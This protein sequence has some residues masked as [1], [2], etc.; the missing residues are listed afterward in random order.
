MFRLSQFIP[1][2]LLFFITNNDRICSQEIPATK[3]FTAPLDIPLFFSG[4]YGE[5]RSNHFHGGVDFRT[6]GVT[7]KKIL[8][9]ADGYITRISISSGNYG[10]ALYV[11]YA[12][13]IQSVYG[14]LDS[15]RSDVAEWCREEQYKKQSFTV[16]LTP[17]PEMF[18]VKKG[19]V[20]A[21]SGNT[22]ASAGPHLHFEIRKSQSEESYNPLLF[23][24][25]ITDH[26]SPVIRRLVIYEFDGVNLPKT[27]AKKNSFVPQKTGSVYKINNGKTLNVKSIT[28]FGVVAT[29]AAEGS[30]G[31]NG[32][33]RFNL[34]KDNMLV[35]S[36]CMDHFPIEDTKTIN[37]LMDY[38]EF[39]R[40]G[41]KINTLWLESNNRL[42]IYQHV[43]ENGL[44]ILDDT[45]T[46]LI[47]IE[48]FDFNG[49][50]SVSEF[51]IKTKNP[52]VSN[53]SI[54]GYIKDLDLNNML[55]IRCNWPFHFQD[56]LI[57]VSIP[58][59]GVYQDLN[60]HY[61][62]IRTDS[63]T[64]HVLHVIGDEEIPLNKPATV[65]I[66]APDIQESLRKKALLA[67]IT[68]SGKKIYSGGS[69]EDGWVEGT[70]SAFGT[71]G[72]SFDTIPPVIQPVTISVS[73]Q[74]ISTR[75]R[76][77]FSGIARYS[78]KID[79]NWI[80]MEMDDRNGLLRY[81]FDKKR[82]IKTGK[83]RVWELEVSDR[84]GNISKASASFIY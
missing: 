8:A 41:Q 65:K 57:R 2:L 77:G 1:L 34:W 62:A 40:N 46:H 38:G 10:N 81:R 75:I 43:K 32:P 35:F 22:G 18:P 19:D 13:D 47:K 49:N 73:N 58:R 61:R 29:D 6:Q 76:D 11:R 63:E 3:E 69:W 4:T 14:H 64:S 36:Q 82:L 54:A 80:L 5:L 26:I 17:D 30:T 33:Y 78:G 83:K 25:A 70:I 72:I 15:F 39:I 28:G 53:F 45:L 60:F 48:V 21:F 27:Q 68:A 66:K 79:G 71:Y 50:K 20:I 31:R 67:K 74:T 55:K 7:G 24:P 16:E 84:K 12:G 9:I 37:S 23:L 51:R 59:E 44:I 52:H 42:P 56:S